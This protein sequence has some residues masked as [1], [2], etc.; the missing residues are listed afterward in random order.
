MS[1]NLQQRMD[2]AAAGTPMIKPDEQ[3]KYLGTFRERCYVSMTV[4]QMRNEKNK[5]L[6]KRALTEY[7]DGKIL[8]NGQL[9]MAVQS[10]YIQIVTTSKHPF[11]IVTPKQALQDESIGFLIISDHAVD[12]SVIDLEE[13]F[14]R[15]VTQ[16]PKKEEKKRF[17]SKWF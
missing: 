5:A 15:T 13:K 3:A 8:I 7:P 14:Q 17:W 9:P 1:E 12:E 11:T 6:L 10:N 2:Q 4:I 16:R